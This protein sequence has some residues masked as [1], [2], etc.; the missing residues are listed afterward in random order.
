MHSP[1][2]SLSHQLASL[3]LLTRRDIGFQRPQ[4]VPLI[5]SIMRI[6]TQLDPATIIVS[7][8]NRSC[9]VACRIWVSPNL[10][11]SDVTTDIRAVGFVTLVV[12]PAGTL[13]D[14]QEEWPE[15]GYAGCHND[16]VT[17]VPARDSVS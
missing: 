6:S 17:L 15:G 13:E 9:R 10:F 4:D 7:M 3:P 8:P 1:R 14:D 16:N 2:I 12:L 5:M 11:V